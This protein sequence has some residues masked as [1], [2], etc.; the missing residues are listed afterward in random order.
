MISG[1]ISPECLGITD[2][3]DIKKLLKICR[4]LF[5]LIEKVLVF[6]TAIAGFLGSFIPLAYY[7]SI[8]LMYVFV[9]FW[10]IVYGIGGLYLNNIISWQYIYFYIICVYLKIKLNMI[11]DE[12]TSKFKKLNSFNNF[13]LMSSLNDLFMEINDYNNIIWSKFTLSLFTMSSLVI[14]L[15]F[16]SAFFGNSNSMATIIMFQGSIVIALFLLWYLNNASSVVFEIQKL[17]ELLNNL[18]ANRKSNRK[19]SL[20]AKFKVCYTIL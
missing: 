19:T 20:T 2:I 9:I 13:K 3:N 11:K 12:I 10:S 8:N 7:S 17:Y 1:L 14:C 16:Y 6:V 15:S 5:Y 18:F 4:F